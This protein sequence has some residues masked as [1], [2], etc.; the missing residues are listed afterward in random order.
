MVAVAVTAI[1]ITVCT[2]MIPLVPVVASRRVVASAT[3]RGGRAATAR[4]SAVTAAVTTRVESPGGR[5]GS[6][7]P[8]DFTFRLDSIHGNAQ[9]YSEGKD[10]PQSSG[11]RPGQYACCASHGRH[12]R[13][14]GGFRTQQKR[15]WRTSQGS[16]T[17]ARKYMTDEF[18][19]QSAGRGTRRGNVAANKATVTTLGVS[20]SNLDSLK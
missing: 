8:L 15:T 5:R 16:V 3:T 17:R 1:V 7:S 2:I 20:I 6:A 9:V 19:L 18:N 12:R 14:H 13:H 4:R 11:D 10:L